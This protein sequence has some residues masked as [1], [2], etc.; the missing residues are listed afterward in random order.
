MPFQRLHPG[1]MMKDECSKGKLTI[2]PMDWRGRTI[3]PEVLSVA[4]QIRRNA[5]RYAEQALHDPAVAA[6]LFEE[7]AAA[8]SR[9]FVRE[10]E[11]KPPIRDLRA[12]LYRAFI[13][14]VNRVRRR[15][16]L[17]M[18]RLSQ[19]FG[20]NNDFDSNQSPD[21]EILIGEILSR[22]DAVTREMFYRRVQGY[23]WK[24]IGRAYGISAHAAESRFSQ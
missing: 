7:S 13:R 15:E 8:V 24:E 3:A 9:L 5:L 18:E 1:S 16:T 14:R 12:Y 6:S 17:L 22:G 11:G 4:N 10:R 21:L 19:Q 20:T 2:S 23:S